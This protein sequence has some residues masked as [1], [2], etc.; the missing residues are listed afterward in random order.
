MDLGSGGGQDYGQRNWFNLL[1]ALK[2]YRLNF[3]FIFTFIVIFNSVIKSNAIITINN[4]L[5]LTVFIGLVQF[6]FFFQIFPHYMHF[7]VPFVFY[8]VAIFLKKHPN[9]LLFGK[10]GKI[11]L[12]ELTFNLTI[13]LCFYSFWQN[14]KIHEL[15]MKQFL[16]NEIFHKEIN[17]KIPIGSVAFMIN[18]R[19]LYY[20]CDF[21]TPV[22]KTLGYAF[23]GLD[24]LKNSINAEKPIEFWLA[25]IRN[26]SDVKI[27]GYTKIDS[28]EVVMNQNKFFAVYF[29]KLNN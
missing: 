15:K 16:A 23:V 18:N 11:N 9:D 27:S 5:I 1:I 10:F 24:C 4:V 7:G 13:L 25:D 12:S 14:V 21:V 3:L 8:L 19:R 2:Y 6:P 28:H 22:P 26:V 29:K 20:T 17:K